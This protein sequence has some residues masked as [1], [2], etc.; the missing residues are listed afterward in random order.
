MWT[1]PKRKIKSATRMRD[2]TTSLS[3]IDRRNSRENKSSSLNISLLECNQH[4]GNLYFQEHQ[5]IYE[6]DSLLS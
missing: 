6:I 4:L 3:S 5:S 1:K 2:F